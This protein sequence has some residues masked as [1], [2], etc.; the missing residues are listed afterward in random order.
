MRIGKQHT[1]QWNP[2]E[3]QV[4]QN[5]TK[6]PNPNKESYDRRRDPGLIH[7]TGWSPFADDA[8]AFMQDDS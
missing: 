3:F 4:D 7:K 1:I 2:S 5:K 6:S 8:Y